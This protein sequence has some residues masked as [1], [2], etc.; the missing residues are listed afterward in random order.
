MGADSGVA[1]IGEFTLHGCK[2]THYNNKYHV[3]GESPTEFHPLIKHWVMMK[4]KKM[5]LNAQNKLVLLITLCNQSFSN[6]LARRC[7]S[8]S[9][10]FL[11]TFYFPLVFF[12]VLVLLLA[13]SFS[14]LLTL[15]F[16]C[17]LVSETL[18]ALSFSF[19]S[20]HFVVVV[21]RP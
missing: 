5:K 14:R 4:K 7:F 3:M 20:E 2:L 19:L 13:L 12:F 9:S 11:T 10:V 1:I 16:L 18:F 21:F 6:I 15:S 17:Y 8:W